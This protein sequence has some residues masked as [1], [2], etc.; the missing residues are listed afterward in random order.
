MKPISKEKFKQK[1]ESPILEKRVE[2]KSIKVRDNSSVD[3][4]REMVIARIN[5]LFEFAYHSISK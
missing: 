2:E 3:G 1:I 5:N 4:N